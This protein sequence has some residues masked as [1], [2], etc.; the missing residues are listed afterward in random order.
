MMMCVCEAMKRS[1]PACGF[2]VTRRR[3]RRWR[4]SG[5]VLMM[6][7]ITS[8]CSSHKTTPITA[9]RASL[10]RL[11][12]IAS[13]ACFISSRNNWDR[14]AMIALKSYSRNDIP[15]P[16]M[17]VFDKDVDIPIKGTLGDCT[18]ALSQWCSKMTS[19][20]HQK[21]ASVGISTIHTERII[22]TFHDAIGWDASI[23]GLKPSAPLSAGTWNEIVELSS[24]SLFEAGLR[25]EHEEVLGWHQNLGDIHSEDLPLI[26]NMPRFLQHLKHHGIM[27]SI[28]TSDDRAATNACMQNWGIADLVD[29][30]I[31]GDEVGEECKPSPQPLNELCR[32]AGLSPDECFVVGDTSNDTKMG[33]RSGAGFVVGVLTGSGTTE[34]LLET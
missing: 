5:L 13:N 34:Q 18:P 26:K 30:S 2:G 1:G 33:S 23:N 4:P 29:F 22:S 8:L 28:C 9:H 21:C 20:V 14:F 11:D 16:K 3:R 32:R 17:I 12:P 24:S 10:K 25:I 31:C 6:T 19:A 15:T 27:I 7:T